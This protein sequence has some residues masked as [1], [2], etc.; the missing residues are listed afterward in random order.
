M[1]NIDKFVEGIPLE[2]EYIP[3]CSLGGG[4]CDF[5][6]HEKNKYE[7]DDEFGHAGD[8]SGEG[9]GSSDTITDNCYTKF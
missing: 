3:T 8:G 2:E 5:G 9:D 6:R 7:W 1:D 4:V